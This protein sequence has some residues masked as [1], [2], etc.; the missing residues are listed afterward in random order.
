MGHEQSTCPQL[1]LSACRAPAV[2]VA[3]VVPQQRTTCVLPAAGLACSGVCTY[4]VNMTSAAL[5]RPSC[6]T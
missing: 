3:H 4:A 1:K 2:D 5:Q 6:K